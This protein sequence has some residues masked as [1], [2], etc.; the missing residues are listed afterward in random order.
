MCAVVR[1]NF[2]HIVFHSNV[3]ITVSLST[4]ELY[5]IVYVIFATLRQI[6]VNLFS[7]RLCWMFTFKFSG[8]SFMPFGNLKA[9]KEVIFRLIRELKWIEAFSNHRQIIFVPDLVFNLR[10][11]FYLID[12]LSSF[13]FFFYAHPV[14]FV[15]DLSVRVSIKSGSINS[16]RVVFVWL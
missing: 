16:F 12:H 5:I 3:H 8:A 15:V 10:F 1:V 9:S 14:S 2:F 6:S 13:N 4:G 7:T 11:Y